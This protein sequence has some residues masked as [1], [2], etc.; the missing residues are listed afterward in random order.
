MRAGS[1]SAEHEDLE[2]KYKSLQAQY[3][4]VHQAERI[5]GVQ[6]K[7]PYRAGVT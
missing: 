2:W 7:A 3:Q 4:S 5:D 1:M 6:Y